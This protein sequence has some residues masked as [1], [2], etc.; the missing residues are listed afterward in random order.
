MAGSRRTSRP[1]VGIFQFGSQ[2]AGAGGESL[3]VG[4]AIDSGG[5]D[6]STNARIFFA[7]VSAHSWYSPQRVGE[8]I[9]VDLDYNQDGF[10]DATLLNSNAG[11]LGGTGTGDFSSANDGFVTGVQISGRS[12]VEVGETW[13]AL[14]P[15][16]RDTA[17][18][19]SNRAVLA[20]KV[21]QLHLPD[22][23]SRF[24]Y[25][26]RVAGSV[27]P[28]ATFDLARPV[29]DSVPLG[30][31]QT[32]WFDATNARVRIQRSNTSEPNVVAL[33]VP[34]NNWDPGAQTVR[35]DLTTSDLNH[36]GLPDEWE[37]ANLGDLNS[38]GLPASDR[39]GDGFSDTA[40]YLAGT[41]PRD[42][43]SR[44]RILPPIPG[45]VG[46]R[47]Q[48]VNGKR[49]T[50]SRSEDLSVGFKAIA[51]QLLGTPPINEFI[52]SGPHSDVTV[53]YRVE[54]E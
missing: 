42:P 45:A 48:S 8:T 4:A 51:R 33:I 6:L 35:F 16:V 20:S 31:D 21:T 7:L 17:A 53:F 12:T 52:D 11:S 40:E 10:A 1:L 29:I 18:F 22:G 43:Q 24:R 9:E 38:S 46:I 28:W 27:T 36:N 44:L 47:W 5:P 2:T 13:N 15:D 26:G 32:P 25:R 3:A 19:E 34:L 54:A 39:D 49:Y 30:L 50:V 37:L 41:N 14:P 23:Q